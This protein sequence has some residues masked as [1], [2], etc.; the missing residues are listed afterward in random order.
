MNYL[1]RT[2]ATSEKI[3]HIQNKMTMVTKSPNKTPL[4]TAE[5]KAAKALR[6][7]DVYKEHNLKEIY[8]KGS[9]KSIR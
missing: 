2:C 8:I 1:M 9:D 5:E 4:Q 3:D 7:G 6:R